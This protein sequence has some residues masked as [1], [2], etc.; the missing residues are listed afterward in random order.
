MNIL[1]EDYTSFRFHFKR[2]LLKFYQ[3]EARLEQT[4]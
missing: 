1:Y 3:N 2:K 4:F